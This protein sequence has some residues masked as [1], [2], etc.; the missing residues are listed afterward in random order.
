MPAPVSAHASPATSSPA[1]KYLT[2]L[3]ENEACGIAFSQVREI[4]RVQRIA[5]APPASRHLKGTIELRGRA[6][7]VVDLRAKFGLRAEFAERV[8][9]V[10]VEAGPSSAHTGLIV[11]SIEETVTLATGE[12]EPAPDF[13]AKIPADFLLGIAHIRGRSKSLLDLERVVA[14]DAFATMAEAV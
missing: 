1:G 9:I 11:D 8:C 12:I 3:I 7:P 13:G 10:V 2:V 6:I 5:P 4:V 14:A